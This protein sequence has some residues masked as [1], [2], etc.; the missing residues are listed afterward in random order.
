M[1]LNV[2]PDDT[3]IRDPTGKETGTA[4]DTATDSTAATETVLCSSED[5]F[6]LPSVSF[7]KGSA[8]SGIT[9]CSEVWSSI[10]LIK[11]GAN[12][13]QGSMEHHYDLRICLHDDMN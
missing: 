4:E 11:N 10:Y 1:T 9:T 2:V 13:F 6:P 5:K 12:F 8:M 3:F 7:V